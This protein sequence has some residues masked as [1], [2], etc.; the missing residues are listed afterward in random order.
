[1]DIIRCHMRRTRFDS[2]LWVT[3]FASPAF[4][5]DDPQQGRSSGIVWVTFLL[6]TGL[7][8]LMIYSVMRNSRT[9]QAVAESSIERFER[10]SRFTEEH[11]KRLESQVER[12]NRHLSQVVELLASIEQD[13]RRDRA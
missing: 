11:M 4:A 6:P 7:I 1:M 13:Q 8:G 10:H 3:C 2:V 5:A 12:L 9:N